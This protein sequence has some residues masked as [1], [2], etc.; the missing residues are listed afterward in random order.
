MRES[1][2]SNKKGAAIDTFQ[3]MRASTG[4]RPGMP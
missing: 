4:D 2:K 3:K 1:G